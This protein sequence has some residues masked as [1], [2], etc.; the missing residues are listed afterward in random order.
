MSFRLAF[1]L[2][3]NI[4]FIKINLVAICLASL[5]TFGCEDSNDVDP[6]N[7]IALC[8]D[9]ID[10]DKD[11]FTDCDDSDCTNICSEIDMDGDGVL[12]E[13]DVCEG[14]DDNMDE[15]TDSVPD[16]CDL[17]PDGD[18]TIDSDDDSVPDDCDLCEGSDDYMDDDVDTIP[19]NCDVCEG[20]DDRIDTDNDG[21]PDGCDPC[22][23]SEECNLCNQSC[24]MVENTCGFTGACAIIGMDCTTQDNEC[25]GQCLLDSNCAAIQSMA[26]NTPDPDLDACI[27]EC[28]PNNGCLLCMNTG[29]YSEITDCQDDTACTAFL[30]CAQECTDATCA[31]ACQSSNPSDAGIALGVCMCGACSSDCNHLCL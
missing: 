11:G 15:D 23:E 17:C 24:Y 20:S 18:D 30:E 2:K 22:P 13:D 9:A 31:D 3:E 4:M 10:N 1:N 25:E 21:T 14:A 12:N 7:S 6:E 8:T 28:D 19:D 5:L 29:C 26:G 27:D 16:G